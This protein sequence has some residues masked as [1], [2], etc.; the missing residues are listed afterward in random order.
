MPAFDDRGDYLE[1]KST[2]DLDV[3]KRPISTAL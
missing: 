2:H 1:S 3:F